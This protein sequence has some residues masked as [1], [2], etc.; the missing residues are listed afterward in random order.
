LKKIDKIRFRDAVR[1]GPEEL[2]YAYNG[3]AKEYDIYLLDGFVR[4]NDVF[5]PLNNVTQ[6]TLLPEVRKAIAK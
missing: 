5:I 6:F 3:G 4:L 1:I 2:Y